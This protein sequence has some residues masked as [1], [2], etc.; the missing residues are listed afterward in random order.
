MELI[1]HITSREAWAAARQAGAYRPPSLESEGFIHCSTPAQVTRVADALYL[2]QTGL[3]L[4]VI[5][6]SRL[7]AELRWEP[8]AGPG[9]ADASAERF[10]HLY[11]PLDAAAVLEALDFPP[12]PDGTFRLPDLPT[13]H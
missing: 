1:L 7:T 3:L 5:D 4:L 8:P 11:G 9:P 2:G 10:P 6:P 12:G 13:S